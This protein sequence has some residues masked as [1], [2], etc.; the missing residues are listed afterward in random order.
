MNKAVCGARAGA[1]DV[2]DYIK[3]RILP[4]IEK[5]GPENVYNADETAFYY[6]M[7]PHR[8]NCFRKENPAGWGKYKDRLTLVVF[9]NMTG[10]DK[11]V[12]I[13]IGKY[14]KPRCLQRDYKMKVKDLK[15]RYMAG[16]SAWINTELFRKIMHD[17]D[18]SLGL[19]E[20]KKVALFVDNLSSH[21]AHNLE[22]IELI[23]LPTN[24]TCKVQPLD[25]GILRSLK[26]RYR[27]KLATKYLSCVENS[28]DARA[29]IKGLDIK[30][31][32][33]MVYDAW[34][35]I[36]AA[37]IQNCFREA[38]FVERARHEDEEGGRE[39]GPEGPNNED[40]I[41][42]QRDQDELIDP[43]VWKAL[44]K[45]LNIETGVE[46]EDYALADDNLPTRAEITDEEIL[47]K[48]RANTDA[49]QGDEQDEDE[50]DT[51][52]SVI[53]DSAEFIHLLDR[54]RAFLQRFN[55]STKHLDLVE[56]QVLQMNVDMCTKQLTPQEY[57]SKMQGR[58]EMRRSRSDPL[59]LR[60]GNTSA[61]E[62]L[63]NTTCPTPLT[64]M[65]V[66]VPHPATSKD[67]TEGTTCAANERNNSGETDTSAETLPN[68]TS[69]TPFTRSGVGAS[70]AGTSKKV[71]EA[72]TCAV[73]ERNNSAE[74]D[75]SAQTLTNTSGPTPMEDT[76]GTETRTL[77]TVTLPLPPPVPGTT[78]DLGLQ[79]VQVDTDARIDEPLKPMPPLEQTMELYGGNGVIDDLPASED[80]DVFT[81]TITSTRRSQ[82]RHSESE[83]ALY[84][85]PTTNLLKE[86][87]MP[88]VTGVP[89]KAGPDFVAAMKVRGY[90]TAPPCK[91]T[92]VCDEDKGFDLFA[93]YGLAYKL[94]D[95]RSHLFNIYLL[96][97]DDF[98]HVYAE[99]AKKEDTEVHLLMQK[100]KESDEKLHPVHI[101]LIALIEAVGVCILR[102]KGCW[103]SHSEIRRPEDANIIMAETTSGFV[104]LLPQKPVTSNY[105]YTQTPRNGPV[106]NASLQV[107][108]DRDLAFKIC[109]EEE[110]KNQTTARKSLNLNFGKRAETPPREETKIF[111]KSQINERER[112]M[113]EKYS[114]PPEIKPP[115]RK[116]QD[117]HFYLAKSKAKASQGTSNM[118]PSPKAS[119]SRDTS[120][121]HT[122]SSLSEAIAKATRQKATKD[123]RAQRK[124]ATTK[125]TV[126]RDPKKRIKLDNQTT[127]L[128]YIWSSDNSLPTCT[129]T[130][131]DTNADDEESD[132]PVGRKK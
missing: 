57:F 61:A 124:R 43:A 114:P 110:S 69:P 79:L 50:D 51:G 113:R 127:M 73:K 101:H 39:Q 93:H 88:L 108:R 23:Y 37:L 8:T 92:D 122:T 5:Y 96:N 30:V 7:L 59:P 81:P 62:T 86:I 121:A 111:Y 3:D 120:Q 104:A 83:D 119:T 41:E 15:C 33:D 18:R 109:R 99:V 6:K 17:W 74:T 67:V 27:K 68:M 25:A 10:K 116:G 75:T 66:D 55:C 29:A 125:Y 45:N 77:A 112:K 38:G 22:N 82:Q 89:F 132:V 103:L 80:E 123:C 12:P 4:T 58:A 76:A 60:E 44:Q 65:T 102:D 24:A 72:T 20:H 95:I 19:K 71:T 47:S 56:K 9:T 64:R 105:A 1:P 106:T 91:C 131:T 84:T 129:S 46:F 107:H 48:V 42:T 31:A 14:H 2:T 35:E 34:N 78:V 63:H 130:E 118:P 117:V 26:C 53:R 70:R 98:Q 128:H 16:P 28:E 21:T 49:P 13:I 40:P 36:P 54:Q 85:A 87:Q 115:V 97:H 32:C 90:T 52:G 100:I 11:P 94:N 126:K